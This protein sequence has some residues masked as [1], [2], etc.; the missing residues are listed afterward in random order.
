MV[1]SIFALRH[2]QPK[3]AGMMSE[4]AGSTQ[5][6]GDKMRITKMVLTA[7][8]FLGVATAAQAQSFDDLVAT[9]T[10]PTVSEIQLT[11]API[12]V[13]SVPASGDNF[14]SETDVSSYALS[15]NAEG[16]K[17][18]AALSGIPTG[19][20]LKLTMAAPTGGVSNALTFNGTS[21]FGAQDAVTGISTLNESG[22]NI[23]WEMAADMTAARGDNQTITVT[24]TLV[25]AL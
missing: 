4:D 12:F 18:T 11:G 21:G 5:S 6:R 9:Y 7:G 15:T 20:T 23:S 16:V 19:I 10:I 17:I 14:A 3:Q 25:E 1:G 8:L 13:F 24:F 2:C 22:L